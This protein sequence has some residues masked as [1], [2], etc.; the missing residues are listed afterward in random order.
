MPE[1]D[2]VRVADQT[3][4]SEAYRLA[5]LAEGVRL[6]ASLTV[7]GGIEIAPVSA[8]L[9]REGFA[10]MNAILAEAGFVSVVTEQTW[11]TILGPRQPL[12]S[13]VTPPY[14]G[15]DPEAWQR[16]N[17]LVTIAIEAVSLTFGG[18]GRLVG[19]VT[20]LFRA[21]E[22]WRTLT[23][24][25]GG[26]NW[27]ISQLR[28]LL[29]DGVEFPKFSPDEIMT[30]MVTRPQ[31]AIWISLFIGAAGEPR[32]DVRHVRLWS[33]LEAIAGEVVPAGEGVVD[34][35]GTTVVYGDGTPAS[36]SAARG[37][38]M[39][40]V[41]EAL[42]AVGLPAGTV[43]AHPDHTLWEEVGVWKH[44]RDF[45]MHSGVWRPAGTGETD[46]RRVKVSERATHAARGDPVSA[47]LD[48]YESCLQAATEVVIRAAVGRP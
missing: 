35:D 17:A 6:P 19:S 25:V 2:D 42:Q 5:V 39:R 8:R 27:P 9:G 46:P 1:C 33:A 13:L 32:R 4:V 26:P 21:D 24:L 28:R 10:V 3:P 12:F 38:V 48:R 22:G 36:T 14:D 7:A 41:V 44:V 31:L 16:L 45:I 30:T 43:L 23:I 18:S 40:L 15:A 34:L 11:M 29:P 47:G 20:E 37:R